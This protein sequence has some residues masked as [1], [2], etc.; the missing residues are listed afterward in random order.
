MR[1][2]FQEGGVIDEGTSSG[3]SVTDLLE[4]LVAE[5]L[6]LASKH[7]VETRREVGRLVTTER[8]AKHRIADD[9]YP[10]GVRGDIAVRRVV[11]LDAVTFE[12][13]GALLNGGRIVGITADVAL[14]PRDFA[15]QIQS[16]GIT[17][18]F[19]TSA[20]FNQVAGEAPLAFSKVRTAMAG[21][22][23]LEA[24]WVRAVLRQ[25][26]PE[27]L[28]NGYGPQDNWTALFQPGQRVRLR[29]VNAS[30]MTTFNVR[31]PDLRMSVVQADGNAVRP[32]AVQ[33]QVA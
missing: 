2:Q 14:S 8:I 13:W 28:V 9:A 30:S 3:E 15:A 1:D 4:T 31:I 19:L 20:L 12:I 21:G 29:I 27:R 16:E 6:R 26:P 10:F 33:V 25:G 23:A 7:L 24:E 5:F 17:A 22:E 11:F 32:V 18:L